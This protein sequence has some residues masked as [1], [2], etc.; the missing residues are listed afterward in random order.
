MKKLSSSFALLIL[1]CSLNAFA[2]PE[3]I[4]EVEELRNSIGLTDRQ[5]PRLTLRLADLYFDLAIDKA[6]KE[7]EQ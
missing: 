4:S 7:A 3:L 2:N 5:R 1:L 6:Q